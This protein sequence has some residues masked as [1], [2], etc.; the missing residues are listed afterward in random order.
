MEDGL[1]QN[2]LGNEIKMSSQKSGNGNFKMT[3]PRYALELDDDTFK[4]FAFKTH[5]LAYLDGGLADLP[6]EDLAK[7]TAQ[8]NIQE[9]ADIR[10]WEQ[11]VDSGKVVLPN[12]IN[13][14][15]IDDPVSKALGRLL[16]K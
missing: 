9:W 1:N 11:A 4:A 2:M 16:A 7:I 12:M 13:Q 8:P 6:V 14:S 10:T 3:V 15:D 5:P